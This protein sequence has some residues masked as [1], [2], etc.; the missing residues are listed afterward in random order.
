M[1]ISVIAMVGF[2]GLITIYQDI[3]LRH[4]SNTARP[5]SYMVPTLSESKSSLPEPTSMFLQVSYP[6]EVHIKLLNHQPNGKYEL[7]LGNG[8]RRLL[9]SDS[10]CFTYSSSGTYLLKLFKNTDLLEATELSLDF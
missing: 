8:E 4:T 9:S 3:S 2:Y 1:L 5:T 7:D 6:L 10:C